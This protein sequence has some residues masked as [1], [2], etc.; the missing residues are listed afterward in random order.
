MEKIQ[1]QQLDR[2]NINVKKTYRAPSFRCL[3]QN[4]GV[5]DVLAQASNVQSDNFET[6]WFGKE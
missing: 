6:G 3:S 2:D 1:N 5:K 4:I